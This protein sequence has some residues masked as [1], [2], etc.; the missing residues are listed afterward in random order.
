M[1]KIFRTLVVLVASAGL[2]VACS[3]DGGAG[4][5]TGTPSA[6]TGPIKV[7]LEAPL[8]GDQSA[9]GMDMWNGAQLAVNELN[10]AGGVEGRQI[11]LVQ[12]DDAADPET[13]MEVA[14]KMVDQ[15]VFAVVGPY[16]S[17]VGIENLSVYLDA[18]VIPIHLTSSDDTDGQGFTIQPKTHQ[19]VPVEADALS[20]LLEADSVAIAV[21]PSAY[22][23]QI[24][25]QLEQDLRDAGVKITAVETVHAGKGEEA[26]VVERLLAGDPDVV[27]SSTYYPEG[28]AIARAF[29]QDAPSDVECFM[30]LANNDPA[31]VKDAG[32]AAAQG[33][34]FSGVPSPSEYVRGPDYVER[35]QAAFDAKPGTWS[36]FTYDSVMLLADAVT[37]AGGWNADDVTTELGNTM[38]LAGV[39]GAISIDPESGNRTN[40]PVVILDVT[41]DGAFL[42]N[43]PWSE[44]VGFALS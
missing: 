36:P 44:Q 16:N 12:A 13:G 9:N 41:D 29:A 39:T 35:Y 38:D 37:R 23:S 25:D 10:A 32:L 34:L 8:T 22:T 20:G 15:G 14:Q 11:E 1:T 26:D 30:G 28:A 43:V 21:D 4:S 31:F 7:A 5:E 40:T 24:A 19:I 6:A 27:Y 42:V 33:C 17:G 18:G 2:A 3:S